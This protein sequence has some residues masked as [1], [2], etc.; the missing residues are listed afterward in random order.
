MTLWGIEP[1]LVVELLALGIGA[2]FLA[3]LLGVGGGMV[4]VPFLTLILSQR[5]VAADLAVK[6]AIAVAM[7]ILT[8]RSAATPRCVSN[9]ARKGTMTMPPPTPSSP[10]R[11][12][13]PTPSRPSSTTSSGSIPSSV[14]AARRAALAP[15]ATRRGSPA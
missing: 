3:G 1:L 2:G 12:P 14:I 6:M 13:A 7:A 8:A 9:A 15:H 10:A 11:K 4:M 5:D